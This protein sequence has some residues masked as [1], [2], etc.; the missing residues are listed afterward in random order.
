M[1]LSFVK[2]IKD[3]E[4]KVILDNNKNLIMNSSTEFYTLMTHLYKW[5]AP[6]FISLIPYS[7]KFALQK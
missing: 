2:W 3:L 4:L 1:K 6:V 7:P 5:H